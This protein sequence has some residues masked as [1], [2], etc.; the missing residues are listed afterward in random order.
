[1]NAKINWKSFYGNSS[2]EDMIFEFAYGYISKK[3]FINQCKKHY[4]KGVRS[5][6]VNL[7]RLS[8]KN[9]KIRARK[10]A[11]RNGWA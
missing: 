11:V 1:M 9:L 7:S 4:N 8:S 5:E 3:E 10:V 6:A 2:S